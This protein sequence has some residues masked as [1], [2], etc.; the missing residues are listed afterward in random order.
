MQTMLGKSI[1]SHLK[2]NHMDLSAHRLLPREAVYSSNI[3]HIRRFETYLQ[4]FAEQKK[5]V[6]KSDALFID[7]H[8]E[9]GNIEKVYKNQKSQE[10]HLFMNVDTNTRG[11]Q[12]W[13][14]FRVRNM[15]KGVKYKFN[16]WNFT[17]PKSLFNDGMR[18]VWLSK[19]KRKNLNI[20]Q[21]EA[22]DFIPEQNFSEGPRYFKSELRRSVTNRGLFD[23]VF[24]EDE[25]A[26]EEQNKNRDKESKDKKSPKALQQPFVKNF[27]ARAPYYCLQFVIS[28]DHDDDTVFIAYSRPYKFTKMITDLVEIENDLLRLDPAKNAEE[29]REEGIAFDTPAEIKPR[30]KFIY[31]RTL[32]CLSLSGLP[33]PIIT[34]TAPRN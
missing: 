23:K 34:I 7:S 26:N 6:M 19:K 21:E 32:M 13:F 12:Q 33:M 31:K 17:K 29:F 1:V 10:Y 2:G 22:W 11:H 15:R 9:S 30:G 3:P 24:D 20:S 25:R 28:F 4:D 14:Y 16:I 8:F 27:E 5:Y 18:P